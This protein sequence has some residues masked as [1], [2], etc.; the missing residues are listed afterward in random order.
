MNERRRGRRMLDESTEPRFWGARSQISL[1]DS[2]F[3][4]ARTNA[5]CAIAGC[6]KT[7]PDSS[8]QAIDSTRVTLLI[9]IAHKYLILRRWDLTV[10][11]TSY[12]SHWR[13]APQIAARLVSSAPSLKSKRQALRN[14]RNL[15]FAAFSRS[16][17]Y[18]QQPIRLSRACMINDFDVEG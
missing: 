8:L 17:C 6:P 15:W 7:S 11:Y 12:S 13:A 10:R 3:P 1:P 16:G 18:G 5:A 4:K 2:K 14:G 9:Q